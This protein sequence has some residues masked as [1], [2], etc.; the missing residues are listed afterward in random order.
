MVFC[1]AKVSL[2]SYFMASYKVIYNWLETMGKHMT[3]STKCSCVFIYIYIY[4]HTH[5]HVHTHTHI[6]KKR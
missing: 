3:I 1:I 6:Y 2:A 5:T 4:I